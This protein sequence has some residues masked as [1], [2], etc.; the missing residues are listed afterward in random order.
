MAAD[1]MRYHLELHGI[2]YDD[3][4]ID[5]GTFADHHKVLI[6]KYINDATST[7]ET[8]IATDTNKFIYPFHVKK[9]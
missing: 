2:H 1:D 4:E 9:I 5:F 6:E 8:S 7:T 3:W